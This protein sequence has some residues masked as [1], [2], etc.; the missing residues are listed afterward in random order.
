M[1]GA[2]VFLNERAWDGLAQSSGTA[3]I[4]PIVRAMWLDPPW[5]EE[6]SPDDDDPAIDELSAAEDAD[7]LCRL[8]L[9]SAWR[10][11]HSS[12]CAEAVDLLAGVHGTG[13]LPDAFIVMLLCTCE[14][15]G[16]VTSKLIAAIE[17]SGILTNADLDDLA[18]SF[19]SVEV[20]IE[21][22]FLW[23]CP[24][25]LDLGSSDEAADFVVNEDTMT[26]TR[27]RPA[28]PL[29]RWA[30]ARALRGDPGRI[31]DLLTLTGSLPPRHRD[32]AL[33]GLLDAA[34]SLEEGARRLLVRCGLRCSIGSVRR[35]AL[36]QL[37]ELDGPDAALRR[38]RVDPN[39]AVRAWRPA[40]PSATGSGASTERDERTAALGSSGAGTVTGC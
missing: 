9:E 4:S 22:P 28:P 27:R 24:R 12:H 26:Q 36:D 29:R 18:E 14:R 38:A 17:A 37:C 16:R 34:G 25:G 33:H 13:T 3:R 6:T 39:R 19:L 8:L 20:V 35:T 1:A 32:A 2:R 21:Y 30:A 7:E 10:W 5:L 31:D 40:A 11:G 15:W 23:A